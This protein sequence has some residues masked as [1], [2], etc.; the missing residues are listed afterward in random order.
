[1]DVVHVFFPI[2]CSCCQLPQVMVD[3]IRIWVG[4][5]EDSGSKLLRT[6]LMNFGEW[7]F[8]IDLSYFRYFLMEN[9]PFF[10]KRHNLCS[11]HTLMLRNAYFEASSSVVFSKYQHL[12]PQKAFIL[13]RWLWRCV[14]MSSPFKHSPKHEYHQQSPKSHLSIGID[15]WVPYKIIIRFWSQ[16]IC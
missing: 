15:N 8:Y 2:L 13:I 6:S 10:R 12:D 5:L 3:S 14:S 16:P 4:E 7:V 1:M 9:P 11:R